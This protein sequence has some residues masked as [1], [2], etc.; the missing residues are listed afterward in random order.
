[1]NSKT[2]KNLLIK[3]FAVQTPLG[4]EDLARWDL[5]LGGLTDD[6]GEAAIMALKRENPRQMLTSAQVLNRARE[7]KQF[8]KDLE[9]YQQRTQSDG[10]HPWISTAPR[11]HGDGSPHDPT[12][13]Y[14]SW[15]ATERQKLY[16]SV[17]SNG[18]I[19][20][21]QNPAAWA[22]EISPGGKLTFIKPNPIETGE[23]LQRKRPVGPKW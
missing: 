16:R 21:I 12:P 11:F 17:D 15:L 6:E 5:E 14:L 7:Q 3:T 8:K 18:D 20:W 23:K 19:F 9:S 1:M 10:K 2:L 4:D 13:E 22:W